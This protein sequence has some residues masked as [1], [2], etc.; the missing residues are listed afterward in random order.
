MCDGAGHDPATNPA[1]RGAACIT[2]NS[3]H[4]TAAIAGFFQSYQGTRYG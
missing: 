3:S 4:N 2:D 1:G